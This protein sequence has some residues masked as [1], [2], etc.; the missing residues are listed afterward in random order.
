MSIFAL[1]NTLKEQVEINKD[2]YEYEGLVY[3]DGAEAYMFCQVGYSSFTFI[4]LMSGN[5][6]FDAIQGEGDGEY[7]GI[8]QNTI[9]AEVLKHMDGDALELVHNPFDD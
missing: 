9:M 4:S 8:P 7:K 1:G 5:R 2:P 3:H 6:A